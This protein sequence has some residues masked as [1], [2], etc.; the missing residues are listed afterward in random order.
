MFSTFLSWPVAVMSTVSVVILGFFGQFARDIATGVMEGGGPIESFVRMLTQANVQ[1]DLEIHWL[2]NNIIKGLDTA[3]MYFMYAA[4]YVLPDFRRFDTSRF[5]ADGYNIY[6]DIVAQ[7][8][9]VGFV[10]FIVV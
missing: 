3:L 2:L 8:L 6:G 5:V 1:T 9:T 7:Q 4:T 10:F